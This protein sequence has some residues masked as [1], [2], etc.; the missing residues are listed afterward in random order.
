VGGYPAC[1]LV[2]VAVRGSLRMLPNLTWIERLVCSAIVVCCAEMAD[3]SWRWLEASFAEA[4]VRFEF[5]RCIPKYALEKRLPFNLAR[6]RGSLEAVQ[7]ARRVKATAIVAHGPTLAAWCALFARALGLEAPIVAH[8]FNFSALPSPLKRPVFSM[9]LSRIDRFVV[10]STVE[11]EL[12]AKTF[13]IP[14]DRFDFVPWGVQPPEV[15]APG[16]PLE[17]GD[18]VSAIGGNARDY[19]TLI[20]AARA[21]PN[22]RFVLVVRPHSLRGLDLPPNV[23]VHV[24]LPF[25]KAM[26][27]LL[28][29]RFM[30]LPLI[31]S[32]VPCGHVTLVAAMHLGKAFVISD[33]KGVQ[34][35]VREGENALTGTTG[36]VDSLVAATQRLWENPALCAQLGK[37]GRRFAARECTEKRIAE[38]FRQWLQSH[39]Q[40][41]S[42]RCSLG[43]VHGT[44]I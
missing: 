31:N 24:N 43:A 37:N 11:R 30:V 21:L 18:Y 36:S 34:D 5:A 7:L 14:T 35:Y 16:T 9:A 12:Y 19:R 28:H 1:R 13:G 17:Q 20:E 4:E 2:E 39:N 8:A 33:S 3:P 15:D 38:H 10:F 41:D 44:Q 27:V 32:E 29:S 22:V 25:G 26:N 42:K 23:K 6:L 40:R